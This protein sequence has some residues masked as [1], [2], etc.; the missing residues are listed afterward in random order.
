MENNKRHKLVWAIL[1]FVLLLAIAI[2]WFISRDTSLLSGGNKDATADEVYEVTPEN[3]YGV[4][5]VTDPELGSYLTGPNGLAL[6]VTDEDTCIGS[7]LESWKPYIVSAPEVNS[8]GVVSS[9][10]RGNA[11]QQTYNG[12]PLYFY[13][14]DEKAGDIG[15]HAVGGKW[16]VARP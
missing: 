15:G 3:G 14:L 6:Y 11:F 5:I 2:S 1:V 9:V 12:E 16:F 7:C 4:S 13:R 10:P 8:T